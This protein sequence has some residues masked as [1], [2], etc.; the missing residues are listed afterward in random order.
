MILAHL[1]AG[2]AVF[3][4]ANILTYHFEPHPRWGPSAPTP[5]NGSRTGSLP[6]T[7]P[8]TRSARFPIAS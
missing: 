8:P 6:A 5:C 2:D 4:D 1:V 7:L 3:V